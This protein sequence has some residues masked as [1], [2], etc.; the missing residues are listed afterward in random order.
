MWSTLACRAAQ[1]EVH[2]QAP[3]LE[4]VG[5]PGY[6]NFLPAPCC[7]EKQLTKRGGKGQPLSA[8]SFC[9][10]GGARLEKMWLLAH[11]SVRL[12]AASRPSAVVELPESQDQVPHSL[13]VWL[14]SPPLCPPR[15]CGLLRPLCRP[16][17]PASSRAR[18][19][20]RLASPLLRSLPS[21]L[22]GLWLWR[23]GAPRRLAVRSRW[24]WTS[25]WAW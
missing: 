1:P 24:M 25:L 22:A 8:A 4:N 15:W 21:G 11:T 20:P 6:C 12:T 9:S 2:D 3:L 5:T 7:G 18:R 19:W 14:P 10:G 16:S 13:Q 23:P 17:A